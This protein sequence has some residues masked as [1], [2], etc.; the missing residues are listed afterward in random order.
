MNEYDDLIAQNQQA[1]TAK[2]AR[3]GFS[4]ASETDPDSYAEAQRVARRTGVPVD[5]VLNMPKEMKQQDRMAA[6]DFD[7][8]AKTTPATAAIMADV[9]R[10]KIAHDDLD[11]LTGI[12]TAFQFMKNSGNALYSGLPRTSEGIVGIAQ[13]PFDL[14]APLLDPLAGRLLPENPLRRVSAGLAGYRRGLSAAADSYMP[15]G[16]GNIEQGWYS[17]LASLSRNLT[18]L[19]LA[20]LPGGQPAALAGM[21]APVFGEEFGK[22][23]DKGLGP[24]NAATYGAS[25]AA[26]EYATEKIPLSRLVGDVKAGEAFFKMLGRQAV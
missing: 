1:E 22:A 26:I 2:S 17:G 7:A 24:V 11:N 19:P 21:T 10:A 16:D 13:A 23:R 14:A 5:T 6:V 9:E 25:Q 12:E 15:R 20:F 8:M 3:L 4:V 18:T